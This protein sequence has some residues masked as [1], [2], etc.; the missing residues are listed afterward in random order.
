MGTPGAVYFLKNEIV[1]LCKGS[2]N[3]FYAKF[4]LPL[5]ITVKDTEV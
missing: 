1:Y 4:T 5:T 2:F 3:V